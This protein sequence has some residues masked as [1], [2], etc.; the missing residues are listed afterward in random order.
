MG[1]NEKRDGEMNHNFLVMQ[2]VESDR[3]IGQALY[4]RK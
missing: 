2:A 3:A 1:S 4:N